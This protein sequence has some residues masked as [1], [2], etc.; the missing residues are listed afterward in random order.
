MSANDVWYVLSA[1]CDR[2]L[3]RKEVHTRAYSD[4][5]A[6]DVWSPLV[7]SAIGL[8]LKRKHI[9]MAT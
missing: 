7:R 3:I 2:L 9:H 8:S 6:N 1:F 5:S 4:V